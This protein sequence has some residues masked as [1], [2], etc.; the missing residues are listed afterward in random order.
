M[1]FYNR[2]KSIKEN[3][4][5]MRN[6]YLYEYLCSRKICHLIALYKIVSKNLLHQSKILKR[7]F[8]SVTDNERNIT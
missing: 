6:K 5:S 2:I 1:E 3:Y 8:N 7:K 4:I